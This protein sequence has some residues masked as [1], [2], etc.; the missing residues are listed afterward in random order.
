MAYTLVPQDLIEAIAPLVSTNRNTGRVI[1]EQMA[2]DPQLAPILAKIRS[3][4][5]PTA[6]EAATL[7]ATLPGMTWE[8]V[9]ERFE[10]G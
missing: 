2:R 7:P 3:G 1:A 8:K 10:Q 6:A 9:H 4:Q 5:A